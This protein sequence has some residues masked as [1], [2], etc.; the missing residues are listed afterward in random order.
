MGHPVAARHARQTRNATRLI[1]R[2]T[3]NVLTIWPDAISAGPIGV[4]SMSRS[5]PSALSWTI[6]WR[7]PADAV[8][9]MIATIP[10]MTQASIRLSIPSP[11]LD[12]SRVLRRKSR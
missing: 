9:G 11:G 6:T 5:L 7:H 3:T 12:S 2:L 1:V 10:A 4:T 8:T